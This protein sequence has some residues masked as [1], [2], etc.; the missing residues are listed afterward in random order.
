M[1]LMSFGASLP[2]HSPEDPGLSSWFLLQKNELDIKLAAT[3]AESSSREIGGGGQDKDTQRP[4][5]DRAKK[6]FL[7]H[8]GLW[9][10]FACLLL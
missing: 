7:S 1:P 3:E 10:C 9:M 2:N 5:G 8:S 4:L 6:M